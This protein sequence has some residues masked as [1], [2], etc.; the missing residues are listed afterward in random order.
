MFSN[1]IQNISKNYLNC[2]LLLKSSNIKNY[3]W[4]L[5]Y[6]LSRRKAVIFLEK[7]NYL[8]DN[9]EL[10]KEYDYD[11]NTEF[12]LETL[13][14]GSDRKVW[15]RCDKGHSWQAGIGSRYR[16]GAGCPVCANMKV[17]KGYNDLESRCPKIAKEW[18]FEKNELNPDEI[19]YSSNKKVWWEC[20]FR[21]E[22]EV[23]I[24]NRTKENGTNCPYCANQ[25]ILKGF[26]DLTTEN[27]DLAAEWNY[28]K[29]D[30]APTEIGSKS[31]KNV[32]WKCKNGHEWQQV[33]EVRNRGIGAHTVAVK[34]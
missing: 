34:D 26:N 14:L 6:N 18:N 19:V 11:K 2:N 21:H 9:K 7:S 16:S 15:W 24:V 23:T 4:N 3:G 27:P 5:W 10:M 30:F 13:A 28:E 33:I 31:K 25:K 8:K 29:N 1:W 17:L 22:W 12:N 20:E 32:W